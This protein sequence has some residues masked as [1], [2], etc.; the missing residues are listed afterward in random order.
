LITDVS[1]DALK[2]SSH[3]ADQMTLARRARAGRAQP[4]AKV[5]AAL[6]NVI[7]RR[8]AALIPAAENCL[9]ANAREFGHDVAGCGKS[10]DQ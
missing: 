7:F 10:V 4:V 8:S 5:L 3:E 9:S 2:R 1:L 6:S